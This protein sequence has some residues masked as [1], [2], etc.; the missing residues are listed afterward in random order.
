MTKITTDEA[1]LKLA[2]LIDAD[3]ARAVIIDGLLTEIAGYGDAIVRRI[4][5]DF[6][7]PSSAQ[8]KKVLHKYAIKPVQQ[9]AFTSGKNATDS[10][11]IIDAMDLLYTHRFGGF[12]IVSSDSDFTSLANRIREEGLQV[13]G[14]GEKKT[15]EAFRNACNKFIFTEVLRPVAPPDQLISQSKKRKQPVKQ[16]KANEPSAQEFPK[17]FILEALNNSYDDTGWAYIGT[18]GGYLTKL[19]PDFDSRLYGFKKL[20]DLVKGKPEIF[21]TEERVNPGSNTK[22]LYL[23]GRQE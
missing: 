8:W 18:F 5:G 20:S 6:T 1:A 17:E 23:R 12:C 9:F 21:E 10:A 3:N 16:A 22:V 15:P 13:F 2:V 14:F 7:L 4:Y 19:K 11:L